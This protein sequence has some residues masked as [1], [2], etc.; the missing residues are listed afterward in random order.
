MKDF[1]ARVMATRNMEQMGRAFCPP[2]V[3]KC[4]G[5]GKQFKP[6]A[7]SDPKRCHLCK[8]EWDRRQECGTL[9]NHTQTMYGETQ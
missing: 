2:E 4:V 7:G 8:R 3:I 6:K 1:L 9:H 5:C